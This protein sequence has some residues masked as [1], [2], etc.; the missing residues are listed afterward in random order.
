MQ[1]RRYNIT[2]TGG[3]AV[4]TDLARHLTTTT[5]LAAAA[6]QSLT[7]FPLAAGEIIHAIKQ[8]H[9]TAFA[10]G[11]I[12]AATSEVGIAG[13]LPRYCPRFNIFQAVA[14]GGVARILQRGPLMKT[15]NGALLNGAG[16]IAAAG[17]AVGD[18]V[19]SAAAYGVA[20][21]FTEAGSTGASDLA[22][23]PGVDVE[24]IVTVADQV[25]QIDAGNRLEYTGTFLLETGGGLESDAAATNIL[26][27]IRTTGANV[28]VLTAGV[29]DIWALVSR[30]PQVAL[31][32]G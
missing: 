10:G 16:A 31:D 3:N 18:R 19:I 22:W 12:T 28:N 30:L 13:S 14:D 26:A 4:V 8:K 1:W 17:A 11:A 9:S 23:V 32:I 25:Q 21:G 7:L 20:A 24:P 2:I 6:L 15:I 27:T 5:A 29:L